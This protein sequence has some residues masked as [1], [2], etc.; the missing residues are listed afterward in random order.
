MTPPELDA[1]GLIPRPIDRTPSPAPAGD[2]LTT[3]L[4]AALLDPGLWRERLEEFARA[5]DLVVALTDEQGRLLGESIHPQSNV[6]SIA[7]RPDRRRSPDVLSRRRRSSPA[8]AF[9][10]P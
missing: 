9:A 7:L 2:E 1:Q 4:R 5:T 3:A 8:P 10:T 6:E